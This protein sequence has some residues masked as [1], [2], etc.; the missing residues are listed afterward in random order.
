MQSEKVPYYI[1]DLLQQVSSIYVP[2]LGRFEAIFHPAVIDIPQARI[3]PPYV[4]P[5]FVPGDVAAHDL[6][7]AYMHFVSGIDKAE[8]SQEIADFVANVLVHLERGETFFV[9]SFGSFSRSEIDVIHFTPDWDA[10]NLSFRGLDVLDLPLPVNEHSQP[11]YVPP[12]FEENNI[13]PI[14][15]VENLI[16][17]W[18]TDQ[19]KNIETEKPQPVNPIPS[20]VLSDRSTRL[21]WA[22]LGLALFLITVLCVYLAWDIL[23][24]REQLKTKAQIENEPVNSGNMDDVATIPDTTITPIDI[25][26]RD[27]IVDAIPEK[28]VVTTPEKETPSKPSQI[29]KPCYVVVGAF[30]SA[31]N[32]NRMVSRIESMGY[33]SEKIKGGSLTKVAI[34]AECDQPTLQKVLN[35]ARASINPD[36]WIY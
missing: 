5:S 10:F 19:E 4:E 11:P 30:A 31:E 7:P 9:D 17:N 20:P 32:I 1:L 25:E 36:A 6:L 26:Y 3:H 34:Q 16:T 8:A 2:G 28:E 15:P 13:P 24:N 12:V 33:A 29:E 27:S 35:E 18:I 14:E 22:I 23:S 21:W